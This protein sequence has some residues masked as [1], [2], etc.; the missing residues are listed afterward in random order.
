[1]RDDLDARGDLT[2]WP[3]L[4]LDAFEPRP[5]ILPARCVG[6]A[7]SQAERAAL[8]G[9]HWGNVQH[10][11]TQSVALGQPSEPIY[12][13]RWSPG[14]PGQPGGWPGWRAQLLLGPLGTH[15]LQEG[16]CWWSAPASWNT[17]AGHN[18]E[19]WARLVAPGPGLWA[20]M[21]RYSM[22]PDQPGLIADLSGPSPGHDPALN[23]ARAALLQVQPARPPATLT[24]VT[25]NLRCQVDQWPARQALIVDALDALSPDVIALQEDCARPG[26]APQSTQLQAAL[27]ARQGR[28][29]ALRHHTTHLAT[30]DGQTFHEGVSVL[31]AW[32]IT[33]VE[34]LS[35]PH[36]NFP[37]A[38]LRV[39]LDVAGQP[40]RVIS[41]HWDYGA[42]GASARQG[43]AAMILAQVSGRRALVMGD[44][45]ATPE[46]VEVR[47]LS[48]ALKDAWVVARGH[49]DPG[50]TFPA[51][52]PARRI[53]YIFTEGLG[54]ARS[55]SLLNARR[56]SLLLSDHLGVSATI[57]W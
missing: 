6:A 41:T 19:Y 27:A 3:E 34:A 11:P 47:T 15:P 21:A 56:G 50:H 31:S 42:N 48:E 39:D 14:Q 26:Q 45:N 13:Q 43:S 4:D 8:R 46:R 22:G 40:L 36:A 10:P 29:Y 16:A 32:P 23:A 17:V 37:R 12:G 49:D 5:T 54:R 25:L 28:G 7:L 9:D 18:D 44:L 57:P 20:V 35:L 30:Y 2:S 51:D 55:A 24:A 52:N 1:M 38:A 53:D 33:Q